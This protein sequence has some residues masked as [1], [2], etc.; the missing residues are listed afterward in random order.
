MEK[1][2]IY[3]KLTGKKRGLLGFSQLWLAPDHILLVKSTRFAEQ[4]QRFAFADIQS[5]VVT[6]LPDQIAVQIL[7]LAGIVAG[8]VGYFSVD[9]LFFKIVLA[10]LALICLAIMFVNI[11]AGPRCRCVLQT[12]ISR[13]TLAPVARIRTARAMLQKIRPLIENVQ[14]TLT[15]ERATIVDL[16]REP[17][18][19]PPEV[20]RAPGYLPEVLFALFLVNAALIVASARYPK[21]QL[22][23]I[24]FTTIFGEILL[25]VVALIRRAGRDPRRIIYGIMIAAVFGIGW[26]A[27][28]LGSSFGEFMNG[29]V[30]NAR[31]GQPAPPPSLVMWTVFSY[32]S[33][34]FA[35]IWRIVA[36]AFG[37]LA[38]W[39]ERS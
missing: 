4:Y 17:V 30:Q 16:P 21:A 36:G 11:A 34:V 39:L 29:I 13:E 20:T 18:G 38:A 2:P 12:A 22:T 8:A 5:I 19:N 1:K 7:V 33:A 37:L 31:R 10:A 25:V 28:Q 15:P 24:L 23:G 26:D 9:L 35:A 27:Y 6:Q 32:G 3:R 14:G